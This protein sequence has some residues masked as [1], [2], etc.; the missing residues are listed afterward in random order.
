VRPVEIHKNA[1]EA[2]RGFSKEVRIELGSALIKLQL[3]MTL[4]FP[5]SRPMP[6]IFSGAYELRFRDASGIQRVFYYLKSQEAILV[7]HAFIKKVQK[8]PL[9]E[10]ALGRKRLMEMLSDE[11]A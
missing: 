5:V 6:S 7:F 11:K 8:T 9:S 4:G 1:R 3:G 10:M 2:I